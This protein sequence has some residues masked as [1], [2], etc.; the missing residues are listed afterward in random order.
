MAVGTDGTFALRLGMH[1][2]VEKWRV[3]FLLLYWRAFV[4]GEGREEMLNEV[5]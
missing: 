3:G 2:V 5:L 1:C 4:R